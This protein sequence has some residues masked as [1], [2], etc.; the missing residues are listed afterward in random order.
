MCHRQILKIKKINRTR[1]LTICVMLNRLLYATCGVV[2]KKKIWKNNLLTQ[3]SRTLI[4]FFLLFATYDMS[5]LFDQPTMLS[6]PRKVR[7]C[8]QNS[9]CATYMSVQSFRIDGLSINYSPFSLM[10]WFLSVVHKLSV[11][12]FIRNGKQSCNVEP[13]HSIIIWPRRKHNR[14]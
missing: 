13:L 14:Y 12:S 2:E 11:D 7:Q 8:K 1:A 4:L 9:K 10:Q 5:R 6:V 3:S